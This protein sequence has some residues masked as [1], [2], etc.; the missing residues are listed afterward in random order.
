M[1]NIA[2]LCNFAKFK[3]LFLAV[4]MD[5]PYFK[6]PHILV[7]RIKVQFVVKF[8]RL[9]KESSFTERHRVSLPRTSSFQLYEAGHFGWFLCVG[10]RIGRL[11][12]NMLFLYD[13]E[14]PEFLRN[15][16]FFIKPSANCSYQPKYYRNETRVH[17]GCK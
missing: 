4:A 11:R 12:Y 15:C 16:S 5:F 3:M 8:Y 2:E 6:V 13:D 14:S 7:I 17:T 10:D 1:Q 9:E